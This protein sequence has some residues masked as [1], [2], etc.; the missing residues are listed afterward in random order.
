VNINGEKISCFVGKPEGKR[1]LERPRNRC[2]DKRIDLTRIG[3][4]GVDW[5]QLA[6]DWSQWQAVVNTVINLR[7]P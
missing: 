7:V 4:K 2:E 3:L 5:M 1:S 6:Q